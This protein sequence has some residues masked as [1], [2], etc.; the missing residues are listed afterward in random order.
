MA[1]R[2]SPRNSLK[3]SFTLI[4]AAFIVSTAFICGMT[5]IAANTT[6]HAFAQ[7]NEVLERYQLA[8][9][10]SSAVQE[11]LYRSADL[12]NS[13]SDA[14]LDA[15][16]IAQKELKY[17]SGELNDNELTQYILTTEQK[18]SDGSLQAL[19]HYINDNRLAG[20]RIMQDVR[21]LSQQLQ[22]K[23]LT[24][25]A[26]RLEELETIQHKTIRTNNRIAT[27]ITLLTLLVILDFIILFF[28]V[29]RKTIKPIQ[30]FI[31]TLRQAA[32]AP[33]DAKKHL[34]H[35]DSSGE[36]GEA[37]VALN[38]L[39]TAT[40]SALETA[41][42]QAEAAM[43]SE[44]RWK[45]ILELSPDAVILIDQKSSRIIDCN[46]AFIAMLDLA[47]KDFTQYSAFDFHPH[48]KEKLGTFLEEVCAN[49]HARADN[50]SCKLGDR[51]IP[52]SVVGV[53]VPGEDGKT[54]MLYIRDMSD[55][56]A[57]RRELE[58]AQMQAEEASEAKSA[59]LATMSHEIRT[60]LN[61][62][63]GMAQALEASQLSPAD[64]EKVET[65]IESGDMLMT[66]LN[67][68]LDISKIS[69]AQMELSKVP[70]NLGQLVTQTH[71]LFSAQAEDK[72]L[73][74]PLSISPD[75]PE[76]LSFDP[77]RV[78]Q[79]LTNLVSNAI[80]FTKEGRVSIEAFTKDNDGKSC[81]VCLRVTDTGLGM[82]EETRQRVF[83][84]FIQADSSISRKFG[85]TGLGLAI[86]HEL[87]H[88]MDGDIT[89]QSTLGEGSCFT[90]TF[91]AELARAKPTVSKKRTAS[92]SKMDLSDRKLLL[93]DD[94]AIN[95][96]VIST[97]LGV[98]G[99]AITEAEN[100]QEALDHL[101]TSDF[102]LVLLDMHMPVLNGPQTIAHIRECDEDWTDIPV[103]A[104]TADA[105]LGDR[106][107]Y[108]AMG[109]DGYITKPIDQR[110]LFVSLFKA[111]DKAQNKANPAL[112]TA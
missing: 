29:F 76:A 27:G 94:S 47:G 22:D 3:K 32:K 104:V 78:R 67:D 80:K 93:V 71:K 112:K 68:V 17:L 57:R 86:T 74:F 61:G 52:V 90:L 37:A 43:L 45:A 91:K 95:R 12:S 38:S 10:L 36:I 84:P 110:M 99:I 24:N 53:D 85:G 64:A 69:A 65:I 111:L 92:T 79:C 102:D 98:T 70:G 35:L 81:T 19:D 103:I 20:D 77:V 96:K 39:L 31:Y 15:F 48:E 87:A 8:F 18:I 14:A 25:Q 66:I 60:P 33:E 46:P 6:R 5:L 62:M 106:E 100:G 56:M 55:I 54:T 58:A 21:Q 75:F 7:Q 11:L 49:G 44:A 30:S 97:L 63:L 88:M 50:L 23:V 1:L 89:V 34:I 108:L 101:Y 73:D 83:S 16:L 41:R 72:N 9:D 107:R 42:S 105:M 26:A 28:I 40:Q 4:M 13:L 109:L 82:N 51:T 59:F 2:H